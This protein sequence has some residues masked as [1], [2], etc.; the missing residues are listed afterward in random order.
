[1]MAEP[2]QGRTRM[3]DWLVIIFEVVVVICL[4]WLVWRLERLETVMGFVLYK[5]GLEEG[6]KDGED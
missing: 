1:M 6:D 3:F 2:R 4:A 5:L